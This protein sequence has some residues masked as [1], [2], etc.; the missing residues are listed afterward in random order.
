[1]SDAGPWL[2]ALRASKTM[3]KG[4]APLSP[5]LADATARARR[6]PTAQ[7]KAQAYLYRGSGVIVKGQ[8]QGGALPPG[9]P[10]QAPSGAS[11]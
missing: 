3:A 2:G 4:S 9:P 1:M 10:V 8:Q 5:E 7:E 11:C 6:A